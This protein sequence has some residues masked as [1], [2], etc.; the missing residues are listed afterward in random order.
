MFHVTPRAGEI[1][2][3][4]ETVPRGNGEEGDGIIKKSM[5]VR[6]KDESAGRV[7]YA[8]LFLLKHSHCG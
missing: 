7:E 1:L 8:G 4:S 6:P 2:R 5:M 3:R